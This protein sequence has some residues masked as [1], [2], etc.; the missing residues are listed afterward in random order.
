MF[1]NIQVLKEKNYTPNLIFDIGAHHG[2]WTKNMIN[3]YP[4]SKYC[5][6]E[7]INYPQ[8]DLLNNRDNIRIY[9][10]CILNEKKDIVKWYEKQNTGDS[11]F[12]EKTVHFHNILPIEKKTIDL[13]SIIAD[14]TDD[15]FI[16]DK[17]F[18]KI[19][20][21]GAEIPILKGATTLFDRTDFILIEMPFFGQYNDGV[22]NFLEHIKY[23]ESIN[24]IPYDILDTHYIN[25]FNMQI[26]LLFINKNHH[27]NTVV[28][29][30]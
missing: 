22:P 16:T 26:D 5:L 9:K 25:G 17:I 20:C 18:I 28:Q 30:I 4:H 24:F 3:I 15:F 19:D 11:F 8:L 1:N 12:K 13:N 14:A 6:F 7:A 21:Q 23:M 2:N 27:F 29:N 10:E